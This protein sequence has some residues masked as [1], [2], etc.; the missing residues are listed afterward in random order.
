MGALR[1]IGIFAHVDAGKTTLTERLLAHAGAIRNPG[2]VDQGTA[3]T[4]SMAI[5]RQRGIS[6]RAG[7]ARLEWKGVSINLIDTPGHVDFA[8]EVER[9]LWAMDGAVLLL[10]AAEGVQ[11]QSE[12][13]FEALRENHV[14]T[15]I[16]VNKT[17]REGADA[18]RVM[19]QARRLWAANIARMESP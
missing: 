19:D 16:F 6:V 3:H 17:D 12:V 14:P 2:S 1:N 9:A 4:D 13:L 11:P 5:E 10:S 7:W 8:A 15:L 18:G